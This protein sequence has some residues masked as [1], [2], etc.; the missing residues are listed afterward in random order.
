LEE[1]RSK[2]IKKGPAPKEAEK[3]PAAAPAADFSKLVKGT[4]LQALFPEDG[5]WYA[6]EVVE[7]STAKKRAKAP[8]K[9]H[10]TDYGED[11]DAW[12]SADEL[13]SKLIKRAKPQPE[14][15][16]APG[17]ETVYLGSK[18]EDVKALQALA[19]AARKKGDKGGVTLTKKSKLTLQGDVEV[20]SL[21][22][23]GALT[24]KAKKG[25]KAILQNLSVKNDGAVDERL[26]KSGT[27]AI[28]THCTS[29]VECAP[30]RPFALIADPKKQEKKE[31]K[32]KEPLTFSGANPKDVA[33]L[34]KMAKRFKGAVSLSETSTLTLIGTVNVRRLT[35]DGALTI[36]AEKG[37]KAI[38]Q[39]LTVK[40]DG[41]MDERVV[42][43]GTVAFG[44]SFT[45]VVACDKRRPFA[46]LGA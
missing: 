45:S 44:T 35:L 18:Q 34:E 41:T 16:A 46:L 17:A 31:K 36:R 32:P 5:K 37:A 24:I 9:V 38:L 1:L 2:L 14:A 11:E 20:K 27:V 15:K 40:N 29:V 26:V 12:R 4:K 42:K 10:Y 25:A 23:D 28:S 8:V 43:S 6:A 30:K 21:Q 33:K 7:V 3:A 39:N 22:L 19:K 13:K